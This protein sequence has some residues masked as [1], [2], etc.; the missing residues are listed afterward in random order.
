MLSYQ[1]KVTFNGTEILK[2]KEGDI[3][4]KGVDF[5]YPKN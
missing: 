3:E 1:P 4:F 2:E 5:C